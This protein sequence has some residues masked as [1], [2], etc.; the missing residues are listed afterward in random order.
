M[1]GR[2]LANYPGQEATTGGGRLD[3]CGLEGESEEHNMAIIRTPS[4]TNPITIVGDRQSEMDNE[5]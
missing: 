1:S 3:S 4:K 5:Q 2:S